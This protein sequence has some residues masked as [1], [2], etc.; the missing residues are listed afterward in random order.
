[1]SGEG[2]AAEPSADLHSPHKR[3]D[4]FYFIHIEKNVGDTTYRLGG[5]QD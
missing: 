4:N 5:H 2:A 3:V 1:M